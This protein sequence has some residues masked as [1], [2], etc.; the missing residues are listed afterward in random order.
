MFILIHQ[1]LDSQFLVGKQQIKINPT[2]RVPFMN[3][4]IFLYNIHS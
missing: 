3:N 1:L 2:L 4:S